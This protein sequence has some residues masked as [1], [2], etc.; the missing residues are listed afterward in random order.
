M[1][2]TQVGQEIPLTIDTLAANWVTPFRILRAGDA[3]D[4][5]F[6]IDGN[7]DTYLHADSSLYVGWTRFVEETGYAFKMVGGGQPLQVLGFTD[8][9]FRK[10]VTVPSPFTVVSVPATP[11]VSDLH[12]QQDWTD[13]Y[14][15][16]T[17][18]AAQVWDDSN[19]P[20]GEFQFRGPGG[21]YIWMGEGGGGLIGRFAV[22]DPRHN[23]AGGVG[24]MLYLADA[25]TEPSTPTDGGAMIWSMY[26]N[27]IMAITTDGS[28]H[29]LA[30][31]VAAGVE[32]V[33]ALS[34]RVDELE[35]RLIALEA[36]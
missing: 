30:P 24:P 7:G 3:G 21:T 1:T 17:G 31:S 4:P 10:A 36:R 22:G 15:R 19:A 12:L 6:W 33:A 25:W 18:D 8:V 13:L 27:R 23:W 28:I 34:S 11:L 9:S 5:I 14:L 16:S 35:Q 32:E 2:L 26:P 29:Q 20:A